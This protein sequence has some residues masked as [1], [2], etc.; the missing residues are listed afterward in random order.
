MD[1]SVR[2]SHTR[3]L[4][5][6]TI[7]APPHDGRSPLSEAIAPHSDFHSRSFWWM[8]VIAAGLNNTKLARLEFDATISCLALATQVRGHFKHA[9]IYC[10]LTRIVA[11]R[12]TQTRTP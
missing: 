6:L 5:C 12:L 9:S 2:T 4:R 3:R 10:G 7:D 8:G 1:S 11:S